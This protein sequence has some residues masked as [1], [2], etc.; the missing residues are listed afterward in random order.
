MAHNHPPMVESSTTNL[1]CVGDVGKIPIRME[2]QVL[3]EIRSGSFKR[4]ACFSREHQQLP[5]PGWA[6]SLHSRGFFEHGVGIGTAHTEG[7]DSCPAW[8][9]SCLPFGEGAINVKGTGGKI[10]VRIGFCEVQAG[11][12]RLVFK[13]QDSF[14]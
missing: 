8:G 4:G 14:D 11:W 12:D 5:G 10:N 9:A 6:G 2:L 3:N 13:C 7:T 1:E